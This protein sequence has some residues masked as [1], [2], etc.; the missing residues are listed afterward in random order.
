MAPQVRSFIT[1]DP[2]LDNVGHYARVLLCQRLGRLKVFLISRLLRRKGVG[3]AQFHDRTVFIRFA[4]ECKRVTCLIGQSRHW[5][6]RNLLEHWAQHAE[7]QVQQHRGEKQVTAAILGKRDLFRV[8]PDRRLNNGLFFRGDERAVQHADRIAALLAETH[9]LFDKVRHFCLLRIRQCPGFGLAVFSKHRAVV[10]HYRHRQP[11]HAA[12]GL[13]GVADCLVHFV[14]DRTVLARVAQLRRTGQRR[15][16][17]LA[18]DRRRR[19]RLRL[20]RQCAGNAAG[21]GVAWPAGLAALLAAN[22]RIVTFAVRLISFCR[23]FGAREIDICRSLGP[24]VVRPHNRRDNRFDTAHDALLQFLHILQQCRVKRVGIGGFVAVRQEIAVLVD[25]R[26]VLGRQIRHAG[27]WGKREIR[28]A[29]G[30]A[31]YNL[32]GIKATGNWTGKTVEVATTEYVNG[33]AQ[34]RMEK[35]RAYDSYE[36]S[37]R[38]YGNPLKNNP[39]YQNVIAS[40]QDAAGFARGLQQAGYVTDPNYAAKLSRIISKSFTA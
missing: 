2:V 38:D 17:R 31:S 20:V 33:V 21:A 14:I 27:R 12:H 39:R 32:F 16:G 15:Q 5:L 8:L 37:F 26:D 24:D 3:S 9:R 13:L 29:D 34:K 10:Q 40:G 36:E 6:G 4:A 30:S 11:P 1:V 28:N 7:E 18:V 22:G 35:F 19:I 23:L 25:H